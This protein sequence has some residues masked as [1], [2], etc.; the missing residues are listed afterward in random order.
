MPIKTV[1]WDANIFHALFGKEAGRVDLC[2]RVEK[3]ALNGDVDIYTSTITFVECVWVKTILDPTGKLNKLSPQHEPIL[4][5]Y[6]MRSCI[7]PINCDR[8]IAEAA[9][10]LLW[11]YPALKPHDAIHVASALSQPIDFM[12]SFDDDDL[13]K[14]NGKIGNPPLRICHPGDGDGF[15]PQPQQTSLFQLPQS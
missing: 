5:K 14:L 13:V 15:G 6:F 9:R 4:T 7:R 10:S 8:R 12:H 2:E 3:V 1:Y 11:Q